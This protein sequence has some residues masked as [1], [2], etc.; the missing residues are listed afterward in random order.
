MTDSENI[1]EKNRR[2][3]VNDTILRRWPEVRAYLAKK[4]PTGAEYVIETKVTVAFGGPMDQPVSILFKDQG[5][6]AVFKL[7][8]Y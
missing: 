1:P 7:V 6:A 8:Y 5:D 3:H 4:H 2:V